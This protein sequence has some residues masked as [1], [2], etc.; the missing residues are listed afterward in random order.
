MTGESRVFGA[1]GAT[2]A[3]GVKEGSGTPVST[4][5]TRRAAGKAA[6][7]GAD[8]SGGRPRTDLFREVAAEWIRQS[9]LRSTWWAFGA[10]LAGM[11]VF[12]AIM[13]YTEWTRIMENP[14]E[15]DGAAF[16]R[17]TS[18]GHFYLVQIAVLVMAAL[19]ATGEFGNR[20]VTSTLLWRPARGTVLVART[21]V[22]AAL[23]FA[24]GVLATVTAVAVLSVFVGRYASADVAGTLATSLNAGVCMALFAVLFVG[25]GTATRSMPGTFIM[26]FLLLMGLPMVMQLSQVQMISDFAALMPGT[27]GIEFYAGG[28]VGFYTAPHDGPVNIAAVVGWALAAQIVAHTELRVRDV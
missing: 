16:M 28:D 2:G 1:T 10:A 6:G 15:A 11:A 25:I 26:G 19:T 27:A 24:A 5:G 22:S 20:S 17:L 4:E 7:A 18:Q 3:T 14:D 8:R 21:L 9:S 12:A 23:A 13:G